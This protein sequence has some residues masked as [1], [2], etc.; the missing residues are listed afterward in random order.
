[1]KTNFRILVSVLT[2]LVWGLVSLGA[3]LV[4]VELITRGAKAAA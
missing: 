2:A 1:M 3:C 4:V